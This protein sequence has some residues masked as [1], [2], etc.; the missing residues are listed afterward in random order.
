M[1]PSFAH[2]VLYAQCPVY[3]VIHPVMGND[4]VGRGL[5]L[6][7]QGAAAPDEGQWCCQSSRLV[8]PM[9]EAAATSTLLCSP[10]ATSWYAQM[11]PLN[12]LL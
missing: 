7:M 10:A 4:L 2:N 9:Q 5:L 12:S 8:L 11:F 3:H 6:S 1:R